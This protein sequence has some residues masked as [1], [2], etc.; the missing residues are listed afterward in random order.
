ME[1]THGGDW[2][3]YRAA[4]GRDALD[5]SANVSPLGLPAGVAAAISEAIATAD[6]YPDPLCRALCAAIAD[7]EGLPAQWIMCGNGAADLIFRLVLAARPRRA[8][9]LAP[10]FAEYEAALD[11]VGCEVVRYFLDE[12]DDFAV[13]EAI[14]DAITPDVDMVFLC[15]PNNPTGQLA[16]PELVA[17]LAAKCAESG[18]R[19]AVDECFL[20]FLPD[21]DALTAKPLLAG[22]GKPVIFKAF[23]K[24]Y[25]MAGVRLGWCECA[26]E[27]LLASMRAAG[28]PWAV[29]GLAEAAGCEALRETAY[30]NRV[31][32]LVAAERPRLAAGLRA[33]G[34]RVVDGRANYLLFR[35]PSALGE[36]LRQRGVVLRS[37]K[38]YQGLDD[39]WWRTAVRTGA[40]NDALLAAIR[41]ALEE[42]Q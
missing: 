15:Q 35:A 10:T 1:L 3:G 31:R 17:K 37:C 18:A 16:A 2:A 23:T 36:T 7:A 14:L 20:D 32:A 19:L 39:S 28:Q 30:A 11:V 27:G 5:F 9:V 24:L 38:N 42:L 26:D 8:L 4:F 34:L 29:S 6:R 21:A 22:A 13:T 41:M 25:A 12:A 40:E 33:L